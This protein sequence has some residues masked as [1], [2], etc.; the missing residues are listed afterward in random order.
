MNIDP[1]TTKYLIR[2]SIVA[3]G[4]V[5]KPDVVGAIFG[6]TEGLLGNELDLR[7]MQK[8]GRIGR[9]EVEIGQNKGKSEGEITI[10]SSLDQV[11]TV[12]LASALE[13]IDRVGPCRA[14]IEIT[15]VED[16]RLAKK[17]KIVERAKSLLS[18]LMA[19]SNHTGESLTASVRQSVQV[20]EII[21]YGKDK[22]PAGPNV[23]TSDAIIVVEGRADVLNLLKHGIKNAIA[24]EGTNIPRSIQ[25]LSKERVVTAFVDGDRGGELILRELLQVAEVDFVARAPQT[26]EVED[27]TQKQIMKGLRNKIPAE[28]YVEM[29]GLEGIELPAAT[30]KS[31]ER[32]PQGP[33]TT[34]N[35]K[36]RGVKPPAKRGDTTSKRP[37]K[38]DQKTKILSEEQ[39]KYKGILGELSGTSKAKMLNPSGSVVDETP[40]RNLAETLKKSSSDVKTLIFDGIITQ[41]L[42]DIATEKGISTIVGSKLGNV[43]KQVTSIEIITK[44]DLN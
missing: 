42:I 20:E 15:K 8:S 5:E 36:N 28:Q 37:A 3:E 23:P 4:I 35:Q 9:I 39:K 18:T 34:K 2:A 44:N 12:I 10:P 40:V 6:Q 17:K 26:R 14:N 21:H 1:S 33:Q 29:Y 41:R 38:N 22:C 19:E 43:A 30:T 27:L 25:D 16:V 32:V 7:D 13:T 11:E 24:V 31:E